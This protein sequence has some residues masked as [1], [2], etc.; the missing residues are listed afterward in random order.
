[1]D[2]EGVTKGEIGWSA[3]EFGAIVK[4]ARFGDEVSVTG[5]KRCGGVSGATGTNHGACCGVYGPGISDG[6]N[7]SAETVSRIAA[8]AAATGTKRTGSEVGIQSIIMFRD[9]GVA[10]S[11]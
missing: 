9:I 10:A 5:D 6:R 4:D 8:I 7:D 3:V 2:F 1:M 11:Q